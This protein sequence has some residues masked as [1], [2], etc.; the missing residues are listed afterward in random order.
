MSSLA[1]LC[2]L[3]GLVLSSTAASAETGDHRDPVSGLVGG[4][5]LGLRSVGE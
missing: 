1:L 4:A 3:A 5:A 2:A